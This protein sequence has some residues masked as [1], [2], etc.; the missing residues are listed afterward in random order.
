MARCISLASTANLSATNFK[1]STGAIG[2]AVDR[3]TKSLAELPA[4]SSAANDS[5]RAL[6]QSLSD[7][8]WLAKNP[9]GLR[10]IRELLHP[11]GLSPYTPHANDTARLC[12]QLEFALN[13][14]AKLWDACPEA[15]ALMLAADIE[16]ARRERAQVAQS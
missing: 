6:A 14:K 9:E 5:V 7:W 12:G 16:E 2:D 4:G 3:A 10:I 11:I 15:L 1:L 13:I 8:K